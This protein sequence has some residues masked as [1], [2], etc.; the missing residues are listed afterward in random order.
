MAKA[1][2][3]LDKFEKHPLGT[4]RTVALVAPC[5]ATVLAGVVP[6]AAR[7]VAAIRSTELVV[8]LDDG[9]FF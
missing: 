9:T 1:R 3:L 4:F 7:L 6:V 5:A 8:V 2:A